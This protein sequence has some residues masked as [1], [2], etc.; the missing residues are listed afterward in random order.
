MVQ[1]LTLAVVLTQEPMGRGRG[2]SANPCRRCARARAPRTWSPAAA[3][4]CER[5]QSQPPGAF[6]GAAAAGGAAWP[7][8]FC[9]ARTGNRRFFAVKRPARPCNSPHRNPFFCGKRRGR[10]TAPGGRARTDAVDHGRGLELVAAVGHLRAAPPLIP[11][12]PPPPPPP[13]SQALV[14]KCQRCST[15]QGHVACT[16]DVLRAHNCTAESIPDSGSLVQ[17]LA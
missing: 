9:T 17:G 11:I 13:G 1:V 3:W 15:A 6:S 2:T 8:A 5:K 12:C 7:A 16:Q 14:S 10:L 4:P